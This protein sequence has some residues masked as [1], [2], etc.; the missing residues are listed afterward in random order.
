MKSMQID[1]KEYSYFVNNQWSAR[2]RLGPHR[3]PQLG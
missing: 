3:T 1:V 2:Q